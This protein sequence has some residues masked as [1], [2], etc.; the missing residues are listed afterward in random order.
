MSNFQD[1]ISGYS[2]VIV[3]VAA[4]LIFLAFVYGLIAALKPVITFFKEL[5][6]GRF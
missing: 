4:S 3:W 5:K 1:F 2:D 6:N